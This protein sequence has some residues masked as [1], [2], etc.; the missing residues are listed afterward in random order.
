MTSETNLKTIKYSSKNIQPIKKILIETESKVSYE[1][2]LFMVTDLIE[3]PFT[4][5]D[6]KNLKTLAEEVPKLRTLV[7]NLIETLEILGDEELME[8][9]QKS[10]KDIQE[11]R[12]IGFKELQKE[13]EIN[14]NVNMNFFI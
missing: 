12:L 6:R 11:N 1:K 13:L 2:H 5:E 4:K 7:E 9:I 3:A 8:S 14:E 10:E